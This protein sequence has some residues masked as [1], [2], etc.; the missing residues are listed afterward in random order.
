ME[1]VH[2]LALQTAILTLPTPTLALI[3]L[4][5]INLSETLVS[6][7]QTA[8]PILFLLSPALN[9]TT[10]ITSP[11]VEVLALP[12]PPNIAALQME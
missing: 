1:V 11:T 8:P 5:L 9:A 4:R 12:F 7:F 3:V 6:T 10:C 2:L